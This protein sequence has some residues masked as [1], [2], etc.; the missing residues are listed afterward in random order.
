MNIEKNLQ[1]SIDL[2]LNN[3]GI[4]FLPGLAASILTVLS[5]GLLAG[6][7]FGGLMILILKLLRDQQAEFKEIFAHF[8]KTLPTLI[9]CLAAEIV[10]LIARNI[11]VVGVALTVALSPLIL[12]VVTIAL[13]LIIE[14]DSAPLPAV[15]EGILFFKT[16]PL[17]IWIYGL[18]ALI[19]SSVGAVAFGVGVFLTIPFSVI[20]LTV[21]YQEYSEQ[22][23]FE[24][25]K[26][27]DGHPQ[28]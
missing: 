6:P 26:S 18:I 4:I 22:G 25:I 24:I 16:E 8:E 10:F 7:L 11:P 23:Y 14:K 2:Y 1:K 20:C 9:I 13:I 12:V 28:T 17:I 3:F 21:A 5:L 27:G 15:K 19:L